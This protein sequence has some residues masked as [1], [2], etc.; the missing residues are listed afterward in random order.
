MYTIVV[1][2]DGSET[3]A[4]ALRTAVDLARRIGDASVRIVNVQPAIPSSVGSFVGGK[5][6]REHYAEE[7]ERAFA[8]VRV[9]LAEAGVDHSFEHRV[10]ATGETVSEFAREV[11]GAMIVMGTRG[12]GHLQ[13]LIMGSVATRV[14]QTAGCPVLL[15]K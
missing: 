8:G 4:R 13:G 5:A 12:L 14:V 15:V 7:A 3:A 2:V 9:L 1:P 10:G 11:E 6:V